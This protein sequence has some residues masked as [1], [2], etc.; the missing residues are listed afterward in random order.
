MRVESVTGL[1][2]QDKIR[3]VWCLQPDLYSGENGSDLHGNKDVFSA[4][5][6]QFWEGRES[7]QPI[8]QTNERRLKEAVLCINNLK[9]DIEPVQLNG[10]FCQVQPFLCYKDH[11]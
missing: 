11:Q 1:N 6:I 9:G 4:V 2:W 7:M 10:N 8:K 3:Y 5:Y